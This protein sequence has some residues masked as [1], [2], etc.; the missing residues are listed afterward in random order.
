MIIRQSICV[1]SPSLFEGF[2]LAVDEARSVGKRLLL[3]DIE[4]HRE[5]RPPRVVFFSPREEDDLANKMKQLWE[6][7]SPGPDLELEAESRKTLPARLKA[8][9]ESFMSV[10]REVIP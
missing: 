8:F 7:Q 5:Q 9:G 10:V 6:E 1:M 4:A 2:G 3:S